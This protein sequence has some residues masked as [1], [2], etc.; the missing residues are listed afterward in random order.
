MPELRKR[1]RSQPPGA[2]THLNQDAAYSSQQRAAQAVCLSTAQVR[3]QLADAVGHHLGL[4]LSQAGHNITCQ[5]HRHLVGGV[6]SIVVLRGCAA[7]LGQ[8]AYSLQVRMQVNAG[9]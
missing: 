8:Q 7:E 3:P 4:Q 1:S 9:Q 5:A 2:D 6:L